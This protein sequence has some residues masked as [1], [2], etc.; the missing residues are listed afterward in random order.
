LIALGLEVFSTVA[1]MREQA[2][3]GGALV[4]TMGALHD[5]HLTLIRRAAETGKP[6]IVSIFV[7]PTQ[8]GA[9][10]DYSRYPRNFERDCELARS[11]GATAIFHPTPE[12]I[13]PREG[14]RI[15]VPEV[16]KHFEGA[17]RP[18][19]FE[20]VATVVCK[21]FQIVQPSTALFGL[22]DLQQCAVIDRMVS[23][24]NIPV[25]LRFEPTEREPDGLAMSSRN[26]YLSGSER[27]IAPIIFG[28]LKRSKERILAGEPP[29][30]VL[31]SA[32]NSFSGAGFRVEYYELIDRITFSSTELVNE[33]SALITAV[34]LGTTR[35]IDNVL[36]FDGQNMP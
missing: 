34:R 8:F 22:K 16:T 12:E 36:I 30:T 11:A 20:G 7:N 26:A 21:L 29:Q 13:Y 27:K 14:S 24:L 18:G 28:E 23:D 6:A 3:K 1:E 25:A 33:N 19:H 15:I 31:E 10:E 2:P 32:R 9:G 5:G 4:P 17:L 35:L